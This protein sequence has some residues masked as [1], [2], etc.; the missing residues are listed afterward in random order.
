MSGSASDAT[1]SSYD[2][3]P[4]PG[5]IYRQSHPDRLA[6]VARLHGMRPAPVDCCRVLEIGCGT[7]ENLLP[8]AMRFADARYLGV[9]L[10]RVQVEAAKAT[11][12][13][14]GLANIRFV[15]ADLTTLDETLGEFDYVIAHG[16][17]SWVPQP[18]RDALMRLCRRVLAPQGVAYVSYNCYPGWRARSVVREAMLFHLQGVQA[19]AERIEQARAVLQFL[20]EAIPDSNS[21]YRMTYEQVA[22]AV[23]RSGEQERSL[24]YHDMLESEN[25]PTYFTGFVEHAA[26]HGLGFLAE[27]DIS[28]MCTEIH[29][30]KVAQTLRG[31]GGDVVRREQYLD[32]L[33]NRSFRQTLLR[34]DDAA[35]ALEPDAAALDALAIA[36]DPARVGL[37]ASDRHTPLEVRDEGGARH[38]VTAPLL[39]AALVVAAEQWPA[40]VPWPELVRGARARAAAD[41]RVVVQPAAEHDAEDAALSAGMLRMLMLGVAEPWSLPPALSPSASAAPRASAWARFRI[42]RG[43]PFCNLRNEPMEFAELTLRLI[44]LLDGTRDRE[45]LLAEMLALCEAE[46]LVLCQDGE[47]ARG[48]EPMRRLLAGLLPRQLDMLARAA[49]LEV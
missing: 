10:S 39:R 48:G 49:M 4:Y 6:A 21:A 31:L 44:A 15:Q 35:A 18:V 11:A 26:A 37:A 22:R 16:V 7:G 1:A 34:R 8:L 5:S 45:T 2:D 24:L 43:E 36:C 32:F 17:W 29:G 3:V 27:S 42:G 20:C 19:P 46:G 41:G 33:C 23:A 13:A 40:A 12:A 9:D 28:D 14:L 47:V 30:E 25:T 38:A